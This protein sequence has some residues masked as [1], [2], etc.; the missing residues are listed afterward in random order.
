MPDGQTSPFVFMD[1]QENSLM[2]AEIM[3]R[4]NTGGNMSLVNEIRKS[5]GMTTLVTKD[6]SLD[7]IYVERD[8]ELFLR[9]VR[10]LDQRRFNK[11]HIAGMWFYIP[12]S[13]NEIDKNPNLAL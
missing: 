12:I 3:A 4:Q 1:W 8:K 2:K 10:L 6:L 9:G 7:E 11:P 5:R 13:Q